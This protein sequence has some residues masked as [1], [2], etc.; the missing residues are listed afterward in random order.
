MDN[1]EAILTGGTLEAYEVALCPFRVDEDK[2]ELVETLRSLLLRLI[3]I[4]PKYWRQLYNQAADHVV[5]I[6]FQ[7]GE[8][9]ADFVAKIARLLQKAIMP[10]TADLTA[11]PVYFRMGWPVEETT[12]HIGLSMLEAALSMQPVDES[13]PLPPGWERDVAPSGRPYFVN[14]MGQ[15]TTWEDPRRRRHSLAA[16]PMPM[17]TVVRMPMT[18]TDDTWTEELRIFISMPISHARNVAFDIVAVVPKRSSMEIAR[19][20]FNRVINRNGSLQQ[21]MMRL[22]RYFGPQGNKEAE[23]VLIALNRNPRMTEDWATVAAAVETI[24]LKNCA[25]CKKGVCRKRCAGCGVAYYC[26]V[27]CQT[28]HWTQG[29]HKS[30]CFMLRCLKFALTAMD[31][32]RPR[33]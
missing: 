22:S 14:H 29:E 13:L 28:K 17:S 4:M 11:L 18:G 26:N 25:H 3:I 5:L 7:R 24:S 9:Q 16:S 27:N 2:L 30:E 20:W 21:S 33:V 19:Y 6:A 23:R 12:A 32:L 8:E 15:T 10:T 1:E 31:A